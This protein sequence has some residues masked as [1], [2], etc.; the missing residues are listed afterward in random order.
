MG[1]ILVT[2][3]HPKGGGGHIPYIDAVLDAAVEHGHDVAAAAP[4]TSQV[5]QR[6][7]QRDTIRTYPC[8]FPTRFRKEPVSVFGSVRDFG[9][10][11]RDFK[12]DIVHTNGGD[13]YTV[14]LS[15]P[16]SRSFRIVRTHH[17]VKTLPDDFRRRLIYR[18]AV[19]LNIF[20]SQSSL[21]LC[22]ASGIDLPNS[23]VIENGVDIDRFR[24][25]PKDK[26]LA[27]KFGA[28]SDT[29]CF[30]SCAGT[31]QYKRVDVIIKAAATLKG[32]RDFKILVVGDVEPGRALERHAAELGV[33]QFVYCG[34][35]RDVAPYVS[36]FDVGFVLSDSVETISFAAREMMAMGKPLISSSYSGLKENVTDGVDGFLVSPGDVE[37]TAA[38]MKRFLDMPPE[39]LAEFSSRARAKAVSQFSVAKMKERHAAMYGELL[40][41]T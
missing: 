17:A 40:S 13:L 10:I 33:N 6:L 20:V 27:E 16:F 3:F 32:T 12:P 5:Y 8:R 4:E 29:F 34:F 24:P 21:E 19:S 25:L 26:T 36:L 37:G 11:V 28:S 15:R 41:A 31:P 38:A 30:G 1:R 9:R 23:T 2:N 14:L 18:R 39:E 7:A 22:T 35:H